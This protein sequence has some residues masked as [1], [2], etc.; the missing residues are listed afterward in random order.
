V[1]NRRDFL[2]AG[3]AG[4]AA[5]VGTA[6]AGADEGSAGGRDFYEVRQY[7]VDNDDQRRGLD[8]FFR[9]VAIPGLNRMGVGPVGVFHPA[10]DP[11]P[12]YVILRH[13]SIESVV[14]ST[15]GQA[16]DAASLSKGAAVLAPP[17]GKPAYRRMES[18]LLLAFKGMPAMETPAK[19]SDRVFQLRIYESP[20]IAAGQKKIEMFND[21]GEIALFRRA[22][23]NPVFFGESL[24]GPKMPNLTYML[25][26]ESED[27]L[28]AAWSKFVADPDWK[29][30]SGMPEYSDKVILSGI[31]NIVL[32][33]AE[34][35]QI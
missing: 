27:A 10:K 30:I 15:H 11:G 17:S 34:G 29:K 32:K 2:V 21:A 9:D 1:A 4:L 14:A 20:S 19:G 3:G 22:G 31:T 33:P 16:T 35:S 25:G 12:T 24:V 7:L 8:D 18:S 6:P 26:F 28:K 13:K 5:M 23:L